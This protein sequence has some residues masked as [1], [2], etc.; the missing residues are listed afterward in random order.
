M[1]DRPVERA[2]RA[3]KMIQTYSMGVYPYGEDLSLEMAILVKI[4]V[5]GCQPVFK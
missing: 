2:K 1:K 3:T 5:Y 4:L